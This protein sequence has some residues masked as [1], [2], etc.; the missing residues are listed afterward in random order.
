[1]R[2]A[3]ERAHRCYFMQCLIYNKHRLYKRSFHKYIQMYCTLWHPYCRKNSA[4]QHCKSSFAAGKKSTNKIYQ[5]HVECVFTASEL[6]QFE[7]IVNVIKIIFENGDEIEMQVELENCTWKSN[8]SQ[9]KL[10]FM[11]MRTSRSKRKSKKN[12]ATNI[13]WTMD[14]PI[15][16]ST[17]K[18][19]DD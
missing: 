17:I 5:N 8:S 4:N 6:T 7:K 19:N 10:K 15:R 18:P 12:L 9:I 13:D 2:Y 1:M 14:L 3:S 16:Y 11:L